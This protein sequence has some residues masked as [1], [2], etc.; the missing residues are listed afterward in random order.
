MGDGLLLDVR[1]SAVATEHVC[2]GPG[3]DGRCPLLDGCRCDLFDRADGVV[4]GLD[5]DDETNRAVLRRYRDLRPDLPIHVIASPEAAARWV[6]LLA[7]LHV[8]TGE[9]EIAALVERVDS[10]GDQA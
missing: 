4:F 7:G 6:D 9:R 10:D 1:H 5:L 8:V 3:D 2:H